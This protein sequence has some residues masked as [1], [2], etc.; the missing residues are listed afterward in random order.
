MTSPT[1][2]PSTSSLS[3]QGP[4][5]VPPTVTIGKRD[6]NMA[7]RLPSMK[8]RAE[9]GYIIVNKIVAMVTTEQQISKHTMKV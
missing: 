4:P 3:T 6:A 8:K 1:S 5:S 9:V 7:E 2:I